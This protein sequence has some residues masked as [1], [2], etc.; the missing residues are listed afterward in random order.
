MWRL[1]CMLPLVIGDLVPENEPHWEHFFCL[2]QIEE[3]VFAQ[4]TTVQ[5]AAYLTVLVDSYLR[6][7]TLRPTVLV[8]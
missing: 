7:Y 8:L 1:A 6:E 5:L 3:I 4:R 2:L